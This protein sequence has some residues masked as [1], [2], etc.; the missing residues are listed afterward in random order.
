MKLFQIAA[1]IV[2]EDDRDDQTVVDDIARIVD[3]ALTTAGYAPSVCQASGGSRLTG[4]DH[5]L[6]EVSHHG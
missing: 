3:E 5:S 1:A 2:V 6:T 4:P